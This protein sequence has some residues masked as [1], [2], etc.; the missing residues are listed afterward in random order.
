MQSSRREMPDSENQATSDS[1]EYPP[2]VQIMAERDCQ[3][4]PQRRHDEFAPIAHR[5]HR[6]LVN[7]SANQISEATD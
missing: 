7:D 1:N 6:G 3:Q 4:Q 2:P 5:I